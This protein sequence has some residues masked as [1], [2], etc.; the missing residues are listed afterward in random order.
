MKNLMHTL[1]DFIGTTFAV[2]LLEDNLP[3]LHRKNIRAWIKKVTTFAT[4]FVMY[5]LVLGAFNRTKSEERKFVLVFMLVMIVVVTAFIKI[6]P[7]PVF[8][9]AN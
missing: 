4:M 2:K 7:K 6:K 1:M 8:E 5:L 9:K 3:N